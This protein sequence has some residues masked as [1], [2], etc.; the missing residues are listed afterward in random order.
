[1]Q[2]AF[3][4]RDPFARHT[5][6]RRWQRLSAGDAAQS[7]ARSAWPITACCSWTNSPEFN[8]QTLETLRQPLETGDVTVARA[9]A[10]L[11]YPSRFLLVAAANPCKCGYLTDAA[12]ACNRAP[13][14][15]ADYMSKISGAITGSV[16]PA[17]RGASGQ[18]SGP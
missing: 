16:R 12:R 7:P 6:R 10:H 4:K 8:R 17:A 11:R 2:A 3:H 15:G 14:C 5:T 9:N 1:M 13:N 18:F